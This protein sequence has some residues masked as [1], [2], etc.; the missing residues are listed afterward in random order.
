MKEK[1]K[2]IRTAALEQLDAVDSTEKLEQLRV[3][4]LG[5]KGE[6]TAVL[7][8]MGA[9]SPEERPAI[10]QIANEIRE[11]VENM[12]AE[13]KEKLSAELLQHKLESEK[14]DVTMPAKR[15]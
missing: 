6:L 3:K 10:G 5:K 14:I 12:I 2:Q 13:K 1:L 7:R 8:G 11:S 4:F 15:I 9:L